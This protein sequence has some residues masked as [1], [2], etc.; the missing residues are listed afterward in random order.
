MISDGML[1]RNITHTQV[2][3]F[4]KLIA[5]AIIFYVCLNY[6]VLPVGEDFSELIQKDYLGLGSADVTNPSYTSFP[7]PLSRETNSGV[8]LQYIQEGIQEIDAEAQGQLQTAPTV[9]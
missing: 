8:V 3:L 2:F 6:A 7:L 5:A 4:I 9:S 1:L